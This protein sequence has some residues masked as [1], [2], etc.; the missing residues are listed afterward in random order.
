MA[1]YGLESCL[2]RLAFSCILAAL[3]IARFCHLGIVWVEEAYPAAAALQLLQGKSL[4]RGIWFD[5]PPLSPYIYLLWGAYTGWPVRLAGA[6]FVFGCCLLLYR[7]AT[8]LWSEREGIAAAS[9]LAFYLTFGIPSAVMALAP[10]LLLIAPHIAAVWLAWRR[11]AFLA[12]TAAGIG[13]LI[14]PKA[15]FVLFACLLWTGRAWPRLLLGFALPTIAAFGWF[16]RPYYEQVWAWGAVYAKSGFSLSTGFVRTLNWLG[17]QSAATAACVLACWKQ[18]SWRMLGWLLLSLAA[19]ASGWRFFPR[20]YFQL[21][22]PVCLLGARGF[23]LLGRHRALLLLLLIP[24]VAR[25]GPRYALLA[26]DLLHRRQPTWVDLR[27]EQDSRQIALLLRDR[28]GT[29]LVWGYRPE[30]FALTRLP[31]GTRFLDSQPLT[32]VIADRHL[33]HSDVA[34]PDLA[35]RNRRELAGAHPDYVIDGLGPINPSLAI[36]NY[37]DLKSWLADYREIA[38]TGMSVLYRRNNLAAP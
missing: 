26:S 22:V 31:A 12:G 11:R 8:D 19:V 37:A 7:F 6:A 13:L 36:T 16:G 29:L 35:E 24:P 30:I 14:N 18:R 33:T 27:M 21:L 34:Y 38:R 23:I 9:F 3:L 5:K 4:Y 1:F 25:F 15:V 17:F 10:D 32:G 20:Y 28:P 2:R